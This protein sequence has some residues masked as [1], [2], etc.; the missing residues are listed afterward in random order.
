[1]EAIRNWSRAVSAQALQG[2][3]RFVQGRLGH[4]RDGGEDPEGLAAGRGVERIA[5]GKPPAPGTRLRH[6]PLL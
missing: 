1:M 4:R 3:Q 6:V 5:V 2:S